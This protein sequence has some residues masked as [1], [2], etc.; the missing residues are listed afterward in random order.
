MPVPDARSYTCEDVAYADNKRMRLTSSLKDL[1]EHGL[2]VAG[3]AVKF[4][5]K[6]PLAPSLLRWEEQTSNAVHRSWW[7]YCDSKDISFQK[8]KFGPLQQMRPGTAAAETSCAHSPHAPRGGP[9]QDIVCRISRP[10]GMYNKK[11]LKQK[12][13][14][15]LLLWQHTNHR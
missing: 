12:I 10:G 8:Q 6:V 13:T 15:N 9:C 3:A 11:S 7:G 4:V 5:K 1:P 2:H 14:S